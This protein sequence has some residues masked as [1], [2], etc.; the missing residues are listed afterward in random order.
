[1]FKNYLLVAI[2]NLLQHKAY[3]CI[4]VIGLAIGLTCGTLTV[5]QQME[6]GVYRCKG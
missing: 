5:F 6:K 2:R 4:N 1:M 3:T